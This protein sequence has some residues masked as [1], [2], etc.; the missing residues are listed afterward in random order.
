[1]ALLDMFC[2]CFY[3]LHPLV[4]ALLFVRLLLDNFKSS[5]VAFW[6]YKWVIGC[7][8]TEWQGGIMTMPGKPT[9][10]AQRV[11]LTNEHRSRKTGLNDKFF[12]FHF[13]RFSENLFERQNHFKI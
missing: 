3:C 6:S 1:M 12:D 10:E 8:M 9:Y 11:Q 7:E 5:G 4:L 2:C 13:F